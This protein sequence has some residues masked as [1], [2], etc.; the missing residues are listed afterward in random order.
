MRGE[1]SESEWKN[2]EQNDPRV[3][4]PIYNIYSAKTMKSS[5]PFKKR[6]SGRIHDDDIQKITYLTQ[7]EQNNIKKKALYELLFDADKRTSDNAAWVFTHFDLHNNEWLYNK[8]EELINEAMKTGSRTKCRLILT[9]L[10][11]QP[12]A[13]DNIR[14][15]FLNFCLESMTDANESIGIRCLCMKLAYKQC[16]F[17]RELSSE[18]KA[19]LEIMEPDFLEAGIRTT[20]KNILKKL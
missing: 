6:L 12:F 9:L 16:H 11:R 10:N 19:A 18:L 20:R 17:F 2:N 15:D 13:Q 14:T 1:G 3:Y 4:I 5:N 7:G 8:H